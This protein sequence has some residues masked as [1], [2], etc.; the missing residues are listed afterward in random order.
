MPEQQGQPP[1]IDLSFLD[2]DPLADGEDDGYKPL[3]PEQVAALLDEAAK[4]AGDYI[5]MGRI[6]I[7]LGDAVQ[8]GDCLCPVDQRNAALSRLFIDRYR[9]G[10]A[11]GLV[12]ELCRPMSS[13]VDACPHYQPRR[14]FD[15]EIYARLTEHVSIGIIESVR[16]ASPSGWV[17]TA[18]GQDLTLIGQGQALA[19]L[20]AADAFIDL[21]NRQISEGDDLGLW[22]YRLVRCQRGHPS[23][24]TITITQKYYEHVI[25][26]G[27]FS[28]QTRYSVPYTEG[29]HR[30]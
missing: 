3:T 17:L 11:P 4:S 19:W 6:H 26:F 5:R 29:R 22:A 12:A 9:E 28:I 30:R 25:Y 10:A 21:L 13:A 20:S 16:P 7:R 1:V 27:M 2:T 23:T 15:D 18:S 8:G 14:P 24:S